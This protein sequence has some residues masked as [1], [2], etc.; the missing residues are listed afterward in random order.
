VINITDEGERIGIMRDAI[1]RRLLQNDR[2]SP[3]QYKEDR[4]EAREIEKE[5]KK[6]DEAFDVM[7]SPASA[8]WGRD[9]IT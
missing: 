9:E 2:P 5:S 3:P 4:K 6:L 1:L 7:P 8:H